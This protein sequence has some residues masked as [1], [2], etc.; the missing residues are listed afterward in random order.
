MH[1]DKQLW[2]S[3]RQGDENALSELFHVFY[4]LLHN[5]GVKIAGEENLVEDCLQDFF[6][7]LY[8]NRRELGEVNYLRAYLFKAFRRRL[9]RYLKKQRKL[10]TQED[11]DGIVIS[12]EEILILD[13]QD[14]IQQEVLAAMLNKLPPRQREV[15]YLRYYNGLSPQEIAEVLSITY[16]GVINTLYKAFKKMRQDKGLIALLEYVFLILSIHLP[17]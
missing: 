8:E 17:L 15:I 9:W 1:A 7:Y 6:L 12:P 14:N 3:F 16:R 5:Y 10:S 13:H 11:G 2:D 4:P